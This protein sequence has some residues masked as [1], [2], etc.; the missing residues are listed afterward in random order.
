MNAL[1]KLTKEGEIELPSLPNVALKL[2]EAV[3]NDSFEALARLIKF[4]PALATKVLS[5]ANSPL[6][7]RGKKIES[8]ETAI[9]LLGTEMIK[10]IALS[11]ILVK[12]FQRQ[13]KNEFDFKNFWK[14]AITAAVSA[15]L[16][17]Q[18]LRLAGDKL[19]LSALLMDIGIVIMFLCRP[20]DYLKV[21]DEKRA[22]NL[23]T[24]EAEQNIFG[25]DHQQVGAEIT[26][27]WGLPEYLRDMILYHHSPEKA[28]LEIQK[29][30]QL[31]S[32]ADKIAG[33]YFS[34]R[35]VDKYTYI[36]HH[37]QEYLAFSPEET[38]SLV[39]EVAEKSQELLEIFDLPVRE[40]KPYSQILEEANRELQKLTLNYAQLLQKLKEEKA[41]AEALA[42]KLK[43][44]NQK[45]MEMAITDGLTGVFNRRYFQERLA[46]EVNRF[47]RYHGSLSVIILDIDHFKKINDTYG[48]LFGDEVLKKLGAILK[49]ETRKCD[50]V[51]RYGG[52]EFVLLLPST[53]L[54]G[55]TRLAERLRQKVEE[56]EFSCGNQKV[57]VTISLGVAS[58]SSPSEK[59]EKELLS[60]ADKALYYSKHKGRNRVTAVKI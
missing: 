12:N 8:L 19:Y 2:L 32:F 46:E 44:A 53:D 57:K 24:V 36:I 26:S 29:E 59:T 15:E 27:A 3:K 37:A 35:A 31:I 28:P 18:K 30:I 22:E 11:F 9:S 50:L 21:F 39:D 4:D 58:M 13:E 7:S 51:A 47:K 41:R 54:K 33:I 38:E 40:L 20:D 34:F 16:M 42:Q 1:E 6:F 49:A 56:T 43:E 48:H 52:E 14:R 17:A 25:F 45:L 55:A 5:V 10:N 23:S 60:V